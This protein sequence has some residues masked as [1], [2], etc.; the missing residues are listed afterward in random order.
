MPKSKP[1]RAIH[2]LRK[3]R[4][5]R[6]HGTGRNRPIPTKKPP[7]TVQPQQGG[8]FF[9]RH[10]AGLNKKL[11][12]L[13]GTALVSILH[14]VEHDG[15]LAFRYLEALGV[16]PN[17]TQRCPTVMHRPTAGAAEEAKIRAACA[18]FAAAA[19]E[20]AC[21]FDVALDDIDKS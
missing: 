8:R 1:V 6:S 4:S 13:T 10:L 17:T 3:S 15:W 2:G 16:F 9:A 18:R 11:D 19:S 20:R 14:A 21:A 7:K 12:N 5:C